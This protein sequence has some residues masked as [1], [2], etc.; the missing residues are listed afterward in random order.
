[1][2]VERQGQFVALS[3]VRPNAHL[4]LNTSIE[5]SENKYMQ[6]S[7]LQNGVIEQEKQEN[8]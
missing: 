8:P 2:N 4:K 1:M 7:M 5:T 6:V 3:C